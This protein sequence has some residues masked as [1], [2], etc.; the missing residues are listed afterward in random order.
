MSLATR[1]LTRS[2]DLLGAAVLLLL[3]APVL[4]FVAI[5]IK[6]DSS[7]PVFFAQERV[8]RRGRRFRMLK[9]RKMFDHVNG[10]SGPGLTTRYDP[11]VTRVGSWLERTKL[12]ELPQLFNV[13][14]GDM[15]LVGP[16]PETP[17][18]TGEPYQALWERVL[19]V[20]P[21]LFGPNQ[22]TH[23]NE[24]ELFPD[25]CVDVDQ[26]YVE[27][28][29]PGKLEV[30][31]AYAE[32]KSLW[33]DLWILLR[34]VWASLAGT[35]T[36]ETIRTRRWQVAYLAA[37]LVLG[38][39]TLTA[40]FFLRFNWRIPKHE[41]EHLAYGLVLMAAARAVAL[42]VFRIHRSIHAYFSL[43]DALRICGSVAIGTV[44]GISAQMLLNIR[45]VSRSV[46]VVDGVLLAL[47]MIGMSYL[48]DRV[49]GAFSRQQKEELLLLPS[50]AAWSVVAGGAGVVSMLYA[51]AFVWPGVFLGRWRAL[52]A[53]LAAAF[54]VRLLLFPFVVRRLDRTLDFVGTI[55]RHMRRIAGH[56][57]LV[58]VADITAAFFLNIRN[59]SR[60]AVM[61]NA[62]FYGVLL[63]GVLGLRC[64]WN[65]KHRQ[66]AD[67]S[68]AESA[69]GERIL[70]VGD[71]RETG[72]L[73][74]AIHHA[75]A[76][77]HTVVGVVTPNPE[78]RTRHVE[79][80]DVVGT[81]HTLGALL[82]AREVSLAIVLHNTLGMSDLRHVLR[83]LRKA[84]VDIRFV[85]SI[86]QLIA[87]PGRKGARSSRARRVREPEPSGTDM[88]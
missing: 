58:F 7:G 47:A 75:A 16:R 73:L 65:R 22:I 6:L 64:M 85:P 25:D 86:M 30:D 46:F 4:V 50:Y 51:L 63:V 9:F 57:V 23:R 52:A 81:T 42:Y 48:T 39:L 38:E 76:E 74:S 84:K 67:Q 45:A 56:V 37:S 36:R 28:I 12:D 29:L 11:R 15:S 44:L 70:V 32:R 59:F 88:Q 20:R 2:F 17:R 8:G 41:L 10:W 34:G 72:L 69:S 68:G 62:A 27:H 35:I 49:L 82:D 19:R 21:G 87:A 1:I 83:T 66:T 13:L 71:G 60:A 79:G 61:L 33:Y 26:Y 3:S 78:N 80:I 77:R 54:L 53:I 14:L 55:T 40:A 18:F 24:S 43:S 5:L 31:A